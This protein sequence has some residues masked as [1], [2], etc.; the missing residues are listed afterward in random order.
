MRCLRRC[1]WLIAIA[2]F[3]VTHGASAGY[4]SLFIFGDSLSD[5][6][7]NAL[8]LAPN[9]TPVPISGNTF[10]P[11]FPYAS[12]HY[13]NGAI[14]AQTFAAALGLSALPSLLPGGT[15]YAFGGAHTGPVSN[16]LLNPFPP[17]LETQT[18]FFLTQHGNV[19]PS[20]ALY[21]VAGGGNNAR[22]ALNSIAGCGTPAC[23]LAIV[24][25]TATGFATD[26]ATIVGELELAGATHIIVWDTPD[27]GLAPAV[28]ASGGAGIGTML[29]EA[30]NAA[31]FAAV[32]GN[33]D[34]TLFD[35]FGLQQEIAANPA[36]FFLTNVT[37]ACAQFTTC[38]P[39]KFL[40]WDGIHPTS[41]GHLIIADAMIALIP[42]PATFA[43]LGI[44]LAGL[45]ASRRR[46]FA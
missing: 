27:V 41:E 23:V 28:V 40:F 9:V 24:Q 17:S 36:A 33:P 13:T 15:D 20:T 7:N 8:V 34:V 46:A 4:S 38:D 16:N 5:S 35:L 29:A 30:M 11:T 1:K 12:G 21:V 2:C 3:A 43:L 32:G 31:L 18:A 6:G 25:A 44:G 37:D 42:E 22:D 14:W 19:A 10:V 39:S 26:I 45:A